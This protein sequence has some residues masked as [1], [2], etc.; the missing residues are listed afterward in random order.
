[1]LSLLKES[2]QAVSPRSGHEPFSVGI[3]TFDATLWAYDRYPSLTSK[4]AMLQRFVDV[5]LMFRCTLKP[6]S[7]RHKGLDNASFSVY[8]VKP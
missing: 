3:Y 4:F 7:R 1:M 5:A 6:L 8:T 2:K